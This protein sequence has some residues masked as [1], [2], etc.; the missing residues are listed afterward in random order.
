MRRHSTISAAL[1]L[2]LLATVAS[3]NIGD[4]GGGGEDDLHLDQFIKRFQAAES[5]LLRRFEGDEQMQLILDASKVF[6]SRFHAD[7][8][9]PVER[10]AIRERIR[11]Q[12]LEWL[13]YR[14]PPQ[15]TLQERL[16]GD[17]GAGA[18]AKAID[19]LVANKLAGQ[20]P[21][22]LVQT[23]PNDVMAVCCGF[24]K[25]LQ[26]P[27]F[28]NP[29]FERL[30]KMGQL[31]QEVR[32]E[33]DRDEV[34]DFLTGWA[35]FN[36]CKALC[37]LS[38][39]QMRKL[40]DQTKALFYAK[41]PSL[42]ESDFMEKEE[43]ERTEYKHFLIEYATACEKAMQLMNDTYRERLQFFA[44]RISEQRPAG[45]ELTETIKLEQNAS[46]EQ[47]ETFDQSAIIE[48][49]FHAKPDI[50]WREV[51]SAKRAAKL[52]RELLLPACDDLPNTSNRLLILK[53]LLDRQEFASFEQSLW[54]ESSK[55]ERDKLNKFLSCSAIQRSCTLLR[56]TPLVKLK[57]ILSPLF[58]TAGT[59][60]LAWPRTELFEKVAALKKK[61]KEKLE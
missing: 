41:T 35:Q 24:Q 58:H 9:L 36:T 47:L 33:R 61:Q 54:R 37:K 28:E 52:T 20:K 25:L 4:G 53:S 26:K 11:V 55:D 13:E 1:L 21:K 14:K 15:E 29:R 51:R 40:D 23:G 38:E 7:R 60:S 45:T 19:Y 31:E 10:E 22:Y 34:I 8:G 42:R 32:Q 44:D 57:Q 17:E 59:N 30:L 5:R 43:S 2:G 48:T 46:I 12:G 49:V 56:K 6:V 3:G 18:M 50:R 39:L 16:L 27:V